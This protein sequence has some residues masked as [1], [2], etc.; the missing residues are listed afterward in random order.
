MRGEGI[1][2]GKM[3]NSFFGSPA[4]RSAERPR[5]RAATVCGVCPTQFVDAERAEFREVS[6][7]EAENKVGFLVADV[8]Q[9][10]AVALREAPN[11]AG[12][13]YPWPA[14]RLGK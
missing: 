5:L 10:V 7:V 2:P 6:V 11:I 12:I 9:S 13:E 8:L 14:R 3:Y 4:T 1:L